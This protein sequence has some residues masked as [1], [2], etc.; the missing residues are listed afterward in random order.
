MTQMSNIRQYK[1]IQKADNQI[2]FMIRLRNNS[3][4]QQ[5]R[6]RADLEKYFSN[7]FKDYE[8]DFLDKFPFKPGV[9]FKVIEKIGN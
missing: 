4:E 9:K 1:I 8:V 3:P 5:K 2:G 7:Y 6:C